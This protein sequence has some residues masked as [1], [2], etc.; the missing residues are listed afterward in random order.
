[1]IGWN[2]SDGHLHNLELLQLIQAQC[3]FAEGDLRCVFVESQPMGR[4]THA[5]IVA[6]AATGVM[7]R[8]KIRVRDLVELQPW[9]TL[10][11]TT[12][13]VGEPAKA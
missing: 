9:P 12:P 10:D 5:Y 11:G 1:M 4:G 13:D 8:G 3:G 7:E 6:D 2:F